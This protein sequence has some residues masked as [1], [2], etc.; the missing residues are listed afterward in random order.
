LLFLATFCCTLWQ[1]SPPQ[2]ENVVKNG[3]DTRIVVIF[4]FAN[5]KTLHFL[6]TM[7]HTIAKNDLVPFP[8]SDIVAVFD[9]AKSKTA[10][11]LHLTLGI[12][13]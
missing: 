6:A 4:G 10:A 7:R 12:A 11:F 1:Y 13:F 2:S 8:L 5:L 3:F 9:H